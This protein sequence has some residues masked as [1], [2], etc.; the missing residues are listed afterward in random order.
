MGRSKKETERQ[1]VGFDSRLHDWVQKYA[2]EHGIDFSAA[3][4]F[5]LA[6]QR[7]VTER[8]RRF[9]Q[10]YERRISEIGNPNDGDVPT[11]DSGK[12]SDAA[13]AE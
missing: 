7:D 13:G 3:V 4:N 11:D 6:E 5:L 1:T 10:D 9:E 12:P 8:K 2:D